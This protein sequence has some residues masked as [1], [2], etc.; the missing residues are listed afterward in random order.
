MRVVIQRVLKAS[1]TVDNEVTGAIDNGYCLFV[2]IGPDDTKETLEG[3][4]RKILN[5]RICDDGQG[6]MNL[7]IIQTQGSI[8][9]VSQFTLYADCRKGH[10]PGFTDAAKPDFAK[11]MYEAFNE[12]LSRSVPVATGIFGADMKID[13]INDGPV[14]I[15]LDSQELKI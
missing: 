14:T 8:L 3:M 4:A 10:R 2:G 6:H 15:V 12:I 5:L 1:C 13:L 9:S 11:A 7:N